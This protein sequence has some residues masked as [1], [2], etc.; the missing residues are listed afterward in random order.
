VGTENVVHR[1]GS[2]AAPVAVG[3]AERVQ[4]SRDARIES[5]RAAGDLPKEMYEE[6]ELPTVHQQRH[7]CG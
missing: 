1:P 3:N 2:V 4:K 6:S 5:C 7:V